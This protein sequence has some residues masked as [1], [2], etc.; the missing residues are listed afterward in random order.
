MTFILGTLVGIAAAMMFGRVLE[1]ITKL[2]KDIKKIKFDLEVLQ[3]ERDH[4]KKELNNHKK[5]NDFYPSPKDGE[6][7]PIPKPHITW[8]NETLAKFDPDKV[9]GLFDD[10][11][12]KEPET[13]EEK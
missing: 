11:F 9:P 6:V 5:W 10:V 4:Y 7:G 8:G 1:L 2:E 12:K 13:K 3:T